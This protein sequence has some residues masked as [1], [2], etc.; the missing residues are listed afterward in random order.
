M[1]ALLAIFFLRTISPHYRRDAGCVKLARFFAGTSE[2][3]SVP[4]S[5]LPSCEAA[6]SHGVWE[7]ISYPV[8]WVTHLVTV[9]AVLSQ[10]LHALCANGR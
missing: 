8:A 7:D 9:Q 6:E 10:Q 4:C 2:D 3:I 1:K 5:S